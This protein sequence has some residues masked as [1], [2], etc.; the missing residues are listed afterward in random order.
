MRTRG[1]RGFTLIELVAVV[2]IIT[3]LATL[4]T[5]AVRRYINSA[6]STEAVNIIASIR[7]GQE[8]FK[9]EAHTYLKVTSSLA[10]DDLYP[11]KP[12]AYKTS[13]ETGTDVGKR[14]KILGVTANG[15]VYFGYG[16]T[17]GASGTPDQPGD[18]NPAINFP[19][20]T[21]PWFVVKAVSDVD[22]NSIMTVMVASSLTDEI[23]RE[24]EGE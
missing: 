3:I 23:Y 4:G 12:G 9:D 18:T 24:N 15:P 8:A 13:W 21:K 19:A 6:R 7:S 14:F 2:L 20:Q 22:A 10:L 5:F 11:R 1:N 17:A 16:C